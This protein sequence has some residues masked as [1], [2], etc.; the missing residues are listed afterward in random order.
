MFNDEKRWCYYIPPGQ[1]PEQYGGYVPSVVVEN[2]AGHR[3]LIGKGV[4]SSPWV[5]GETL[6]EAEEV[7]KVRNNRLG[8]SE[9][10]AMDIVT[11]S[12]RLQ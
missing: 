8:I 10:A 12:M 1:N 11:S 3:T 9:E 7:A 4:Y 2:E 6:E 5:W